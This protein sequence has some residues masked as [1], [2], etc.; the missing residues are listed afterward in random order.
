MNVVEI[1]KETFLERIADVDTDPKGWKHL[2]DKPILVDFFA[3][4]CGPCKAL[5]PI[6]EEIAGEY[7]DRIDVY[8]VDVDKEKELTIHFNVRTVPTLLFTKPG[9]QTPKLMLGVMGKE[10]LKR[11]IEELLL[12]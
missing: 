1:N 6:L 10:E 5:S 11:H 2:G 9:L 8:K 3:T 4:W 12:S 7:A